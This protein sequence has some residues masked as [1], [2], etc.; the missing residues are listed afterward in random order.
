MTTP[1]KRAA[2]RKAAKAGGKGRVSGPPPALA[3]PEE[4][5]IAA[6]AKGPYGKKQ[7]YTFEPSVGEPI[8]FPH[9]S[10]VNADAHFFWKIYGLNEMFQ[11]FEWMIKADVPRSVQERVM[12][13]P[14]AEK[15]AFFSGWFSAV[16]TPQG[17]APPGE[18]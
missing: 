4:F 7:T 17:V 18:S 12:L 2:P 9:I 6:S 13:L 16:T 15:Q 10:E 1:V 3:A 8:V 14:D 11:A 5:K